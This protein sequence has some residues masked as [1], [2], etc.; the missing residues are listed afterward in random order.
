MAIYTLTRLDADERQPC[1]SAGDQQQPCSGNAATYRARRTDGR[2]RTLCSNHAAQLAH[3]NGITFP[4]AFKEP[5][6]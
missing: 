2:T 4:I 5:T 1:Q 3:A 6:R